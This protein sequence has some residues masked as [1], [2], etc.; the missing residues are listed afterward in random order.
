[1]PCPLFGGTSRLFVPEVSLMASVELV[2]PGD[3]FECR[4]V[5]G[6]HSLEELGGLAGSPRPDP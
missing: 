3:V 1:M 4:M 2:K 5:P 6:I